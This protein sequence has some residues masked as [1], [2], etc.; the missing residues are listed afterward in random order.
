MFS[1]SRLGLDDL[2]PLTLPSLA[3]SRQTRWYLDEAVELQ[4][5][6]G[7]GGT[8]GSVCALSPQNIAL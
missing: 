5:K 1:Q 7:K 8:E 3:G 6:L 4:Q 2:T